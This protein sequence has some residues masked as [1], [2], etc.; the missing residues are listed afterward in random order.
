MV[1]AYLASLGCK[2]IAEDATNRGRIDLS[3]HLPDKLY[4]IEFKV[5]QPDTAIGQILA[6]RYHEK[7]QDQGREIY[8]IGIGF[9]STDKNISDFQ[10]QRL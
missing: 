5:D 2:I 4:I 6:K 3:I 9:D 1:Y 10:W 7:Y 8:I